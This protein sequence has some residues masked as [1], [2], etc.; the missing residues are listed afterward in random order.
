M[1]TNFGAKF[2]D[3]QLFGTLAF[4]NGLKYCNIDEWIGTTD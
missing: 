1:T 4:Q 2:A 3:Q